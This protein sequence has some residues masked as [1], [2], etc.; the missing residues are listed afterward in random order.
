MR[1]Q[2]CLDGGQTDQ[3]EILIVIFGGMFSA[4]M[5]CQYLST[6]S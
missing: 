4:S 5:A 1:R 2:S 6:H 3:Q